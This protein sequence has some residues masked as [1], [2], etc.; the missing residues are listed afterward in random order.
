M[1]SYSCGR[2]AASEAYGKVM[3]PR[4]SGLATIGLGILALVVGLLILGGGFPWFGRL[5][6]DVRIVSEHVRLY[7]PIT[8]MAFVSLVLTAVYGLLRRVL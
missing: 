7:V 1:M 4:S 6:G 5:P 2:R 3:A 8:S